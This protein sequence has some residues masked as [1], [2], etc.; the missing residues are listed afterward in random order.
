MPSKTRKAAAAQ[1]LPT[2]PKELI[3]QF[4]NGPMSAQ[5]VAG[6]LRWRQVNNYHQLKAV[7][8]AETTPVA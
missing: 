1:A 6:R 4:V 7:K 8:A 2:I 3:D 5:V